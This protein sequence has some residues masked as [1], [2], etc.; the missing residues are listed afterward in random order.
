MMIQLRLVGATAS[1]PLGAMALACCDWK[2]ERG[3]TNDN[4]KH[5]HT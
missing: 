5:K 1:T 4:N 3:A 2:G